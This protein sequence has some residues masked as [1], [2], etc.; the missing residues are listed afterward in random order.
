MGAAAEYRYFEAGRPQ[1]FGELQGHRAHHQGEDGIDIG[2][3]R[4]DVGTEVLGA[5]RRPDFLHDL[6][7]AV[8]E[9]LLEAACCL[10]T[11]CIV[12]G[13]E[14]DPFVALLAGPVAKR[15]SRRSEEHTS[16]LQSL[17]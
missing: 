3:D 2:L 8:L 15:M 6:A 9:R 7:A 4:R 11:K 1:L 13:D 17:R 5:D 16:E 12:G 10:V 14:A